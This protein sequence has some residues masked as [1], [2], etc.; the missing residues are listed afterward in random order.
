MPGVAPASRALA[1]A[2]CPRL[3]LTRPATQSRP[4]A[5]TPP[6]L[7]YPAHRCT[8][9]QVLDTGSMRLFGASTRDQVAGS[10]L[11]RGVGCERDELS[12]S[13]V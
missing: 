6:L 11:P 1:A 10:R 8:D 12:G 9:G 13:P 2:R 7:A 5:Q 4:A 3:S